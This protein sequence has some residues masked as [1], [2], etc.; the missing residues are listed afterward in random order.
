[1]LILLEI[2]LPI[3]V[4]GPSHHENNFSSES[5][6][7]SNA[8]HDGPYMYAIQ[9]TGL[10]SL[11]VSQSVYGMPLSTIMI[12]DAKYWAVIRIFN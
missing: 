7:R 2:G 8:M 3:C 9:K 11:N 12:T 6:G 4:N 1:M 5:K 10:S